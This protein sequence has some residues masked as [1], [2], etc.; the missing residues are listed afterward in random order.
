LESGPCQTCATG[1]RRTKQYKDAGSR[2]SI[3][4]QATEDAV[5]RRSAAARRVRMA[6]ARL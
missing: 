1:E 6:R 5:M 2:N 3:A 4:I